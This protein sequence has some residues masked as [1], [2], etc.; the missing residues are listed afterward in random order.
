MGIEFNAKVM[1]GFWVEDFNSDELKEEVQEA[2]AKGDLDYASPCYD[3]SFEKSFVGIN[4]PL[5]NLSKEQAIEK[6]MD[7]VDDSKKNTLLKKVE[8]AGIKLVVNCT[9]HVY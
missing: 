5:F 4:I 7:A 2:I 9:L 6:I 3:A 8:E 1:Y